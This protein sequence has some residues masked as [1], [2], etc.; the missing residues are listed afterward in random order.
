[1]N[2]AV[3][4]DAIDQACNASLSSRDGW[5]VLGT[6]GFEVLVLLRC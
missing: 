2:C 4:I 5:F 1:M 6:C 3:Y